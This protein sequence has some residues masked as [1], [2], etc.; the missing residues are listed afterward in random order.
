MEGFRLD[1]PRDAGRVEILER[2]TRYVV[3]LAGGHKTGFF[4]DQRENRELVA[5]L[6]KGRRVFD[7][8]TYTG[9]FAVAALAFAL[10]SLLVVAAAYALTPDH[11]AA[12]GR[13]LGEVTGAPL[14]PAA[15]EPSSYTKG[16][17]SLLKRLGNAAPKSAS[18]TSKL[19]QRLVVAD[20]HLV[21]TVRRKTRR[22]RGGVRR[23]D[24]T[25]SV[26]PTLL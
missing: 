17:T 25:V 15:D 8:M 26:P 2:G 7:G 20:Q 19:Q 18:E 21:H 6:S 10:A 13:R 12:L 5:R 11:A 24:V 16:L 9:G 4:L 3:D 14:R 23:T 22:S 1:P